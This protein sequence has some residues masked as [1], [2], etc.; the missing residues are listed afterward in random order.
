M[1]PEGRPQNYS[2]MYYNN[3]VSSSPWVDTICLSSL[4]RGLLGNTYRIGGPL[5]PITGSESLKSPTFVSIKC[6][7]E[8][9]ERRLLPLPHSPCVRVMPYLRTMQDRGKSNV[10]VT[11][12]GRVRA[13]LYPEISGILTVSMVELGKM[14]SSLRSNL[15]G[16]DDRFFLASIWS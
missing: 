15:P 8:P 13:H 6:K 9:R 11:V 1:S 16:L 10:S 2:K 7:A 5:A 4:T 12:R 3:S 14:Q